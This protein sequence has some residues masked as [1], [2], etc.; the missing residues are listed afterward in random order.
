MVFKGILLRLSQIV[1]AAAAINLLLL[2]G[3]M[4]F[5]ARLD[6]AVNFALMSGGAWILWA[7]LSLFVL[8]STVELVREVA[9]VVY[10]GG[11]LLSLA[12]SVFCG[13]YAESL[14]E[15]PEREIWTFISAGVLI[16]ITMIIKCFDI[17]WLR[18]A[19]EVRPTRPGPN[20]DDEYGPML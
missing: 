14:I 2:G 16:G 9:I 1:S 4:L 13:Y 5:K 17:Q 8:R 11:A 6:E 18:T 12:L 3:T 15:N 10:P 19:E 7:V 20:L